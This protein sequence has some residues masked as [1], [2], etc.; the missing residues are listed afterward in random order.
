MNVDEN[1]NSTLDN[2]N[3]IMPFIEYGTVIPIISNAFRIEE[4]FRDDRELLKNMEVGSEFY[5]EVR[6]I[7]QQLTKNWAKKIGYPMSDHHNLARVAQYRQVESGDPELGKIEYIKFLNDRLLLLCEN[8]KGYEDKVRQLSMQTQRLIFSDT[9]QQL[10][11]PRQYP[12]GREDPLRLLAKLPLP[13]YITTSY[14]NFLE[15]ALEAEG[16]APRI[17]LCFLSTSHL[18]VNHKHLPDPDYN[19]TPTNPAVYHFFGLE[20]YKNTLILSEDDYMYFLMNA[21]EEINSQDLYPSPL[22]LALPESRLILLGYN[23]RDWDFRA[24][25]RFIL[26]VRRTVTVRPSIAIQLKPNLEKKENEV[27]ILK[28]LK[29]YFEDY[30]FR[31]KWTGAEKF[32][33]E[34]WDTW[35]KYRQGQ[36]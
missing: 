11:F 15:R 6:T 23:L 17:Q 30:K 24:L 28:Y 14:S 20:N 8:E 22:R 35:N 5:D 36:L 13:I 4:I 27:R 9:V 19:P 7:D 16:K 32:I 25:F 34:L 3:D 18:G 33:Y 12:D 29:K 31:V 26:R 10:D 2:L 1:N 21:V